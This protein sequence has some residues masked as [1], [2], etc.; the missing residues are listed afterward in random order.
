MNYKAKKFF[1]WLLCVVL[2]AAISVILINSLIANIHNVSML[3]EWKSFG[4]DM[5]KFG[6]VCA[7]FFTNFGNGIAN[8]FK[9]IF[10][11]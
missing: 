10:K 2:V 6:K 11:K 3:Q 9:K 1:L 7:K 8:F 4:S 5:A